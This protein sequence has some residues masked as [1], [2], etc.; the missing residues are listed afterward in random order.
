MPARKVSLKNPGLIIQL[1]DLNQDEG[2]SVVDLDP[3]VKATDSQ[4]F[5]YAFG[6]MELLPTI[7][8]H[9]TNLE[10]WFAILTMTICNMEMVMFINL[11]IGP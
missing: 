2:W 3:V 8:P 4:Y 7:Y 10:F 9:L 6:E 5:P 11:T 1:L